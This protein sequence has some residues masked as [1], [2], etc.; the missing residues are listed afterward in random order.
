ML[1]GTNYE[2]AYYKPTTAELIQAGKVA[3]FGWYQERGTY[4]SDGNFVD[5][6]SLK[7]YA[8]TQQLVWETLNQSNGRFV[9]DNI[10]NEYIA[11]KNE[12][13]QKMTRMQTK[14]SFD[15][16]TVTIRTG[17]TTTL[18]DSNGTLADYN[19]VDVTENGIRITHNKGENTMQIQVSEDCTI[20]NYRISDDMFRQWGLIKTDTENKDT[21]VYIE[22]AN[23]VQ[24]QLYSLNYNDPTAM[25]L[26]LAVEAK[27]KLEITKLDTNGTL[28]DGAIFRITSADGY[29]NT[30][31]VTNGKIVVEDLKAGIYTIKEVSAP[32]GYLLNT[33]SYNVE[34]KP[35]DT[36][37]KTIPNDEPV[38]ELTLEKTDKQT[39]NQNRADG[40]SHHGDATIEGAVYTLYAKNDIYNVSR[41]LKYFSK[42][43]PIATFTFDRYGV[44]SVKITNT[45]TKAEISIKGN[46]LKGLP[47][48]EYCVK[49]TTVPTGYT[50]DTEIYNYTF[51][52]QNSTTAVIEVAGT[53]KN[54]VQKAP[55]E[56]VKV[57][58]D[59][60]DT[61]KVVENAEFT[62][63]LTRYVAYYGSFDEALKHID[64][65]AE[66][67][68]SIFRTRL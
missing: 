44:A 25:K 17:E 51:S 50:Q 36:V 22:F 5:P 45:S 52:Y 8:F 33:K 27:G 4:G 63:I 13:N 28:I 66:D 23:E 30:V 10:Q 49:E 64:E 1:H 55:F 67:E 53:V 34:V 46:T 29:D 42:D 61:A 7:Q 38:G 14:P 41:S 62:A 65:F 54:I 56:V 11:F 20:E 12:V 19:S 57:S 21:T 40:T 24:D 9:E 6:T 15:G 68:Y 18:T 60:N 16:T 26:T 3:Y 39:G 47:M 2:G 31:T 59:T 48:G 35:S 37:N 58:T 32:H 43:E